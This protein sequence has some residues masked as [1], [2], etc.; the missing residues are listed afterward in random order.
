MAT[1]VKEY[2]LDDI[3][4]DKLND[5]NNI[6]YLS[7]STDGTTYDVTTSAKAITFRAST[8]NTGGVVITTDEGAYTVLTPTGEQIAPGTFVASFYYTLYFKPNDSTYVYDPVLFSIDAHSK[9]EANALFVNVA[10]DDMSG[11]LAFTIPN[12]RILGPLGSQKFAFNDAGSSYMTA[13]DGTQVICYA[14]DRTYKIQMNESLEVQGNIFLNDPD[15]RILGAL[16]LQKFAFNSVG[17]AYMTAE[18]GTQVTCFGDARDYKVQSSHNMEVKGNFKVDGIIDNRSFNYFYDKNVNLA[19][20]NSVDLTSLLGS[21]VPSAIGY[22]AMQITFS[23]GVTITHYLADENPLISLG[24]NYH[25]VSQQDTDHYFLSINLRFENGTLSYES[26]LFNYINNTE[27][28]T[29]PTITK[30]R[31]LKA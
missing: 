28:L 29:M 31:L 15:G 13:E 1:D 27:N 22:R 14:L 4:K 20:G 11:N 23:S 24:K 30:I 6:V 9:G 21:N 5:K 12:G 25:L 19:L 17:S 16:G 7:T 18:D 3:V 2:Q 26:G 10:G 8:T